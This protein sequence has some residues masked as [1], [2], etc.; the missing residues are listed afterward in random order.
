MSVASFAVPARSVKERA[1]RSRP[2]GPPQVESPPSLSVVEGS[3]GHLRQALIPVMVAALV[4]F[5]ATVVVPLVLN[6]TMASLSYEI[7]DQRIE[8]AQTQARIESLETQLLM[9][10]STDH[11]RKEARAIGL[12]PAGAIGVISLEEG[13]VTGGA[14]AK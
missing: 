10:D 2:V 14:P 1:Q 9:L 4:L 13:T 8:T 3:K 7:R 6:T 12:V 11:L 5:V